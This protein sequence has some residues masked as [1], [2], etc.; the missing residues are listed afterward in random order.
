MILCPLPIAELAK[1]GRNMEFW[2][3]P[4]LVRLRATRFV[5]PFTKLEVIDDF[6]MNWIYN[7]ENLRLTCLPL[8][9]RIPCCSGLH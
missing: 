3:M 4:T 2:S 7:M 8:A 9:R 5:E 1:L 6:Y